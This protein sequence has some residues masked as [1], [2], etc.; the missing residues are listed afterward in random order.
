MQFG[1]GSLTS[2]AIVPLNILVNKGVWLNAK[3]GDDD[4][5][6]TIMG[7]YVNETKE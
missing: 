2:L 6:M 7:Y 1:M 4:V 5:H 3:T